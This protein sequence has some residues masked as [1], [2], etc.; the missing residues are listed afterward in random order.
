MQPTDVPVRDYLYGKD[1]RPFAPKQVA[2]ELVAARV[3]P[4]DPLYPSMVK[5]VNAAVRRVIRSEAEGGIPRWQW[6]GTNALYQRVAAMSKDTI[7]SLMFRNEATIEGF[8]RREKMLRNVLAAKEG[9]TP[10]EADAETQAWVRD[11][12]NR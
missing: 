6:T 3:D 1:D 10:A 4:A 8:M 2:A 5:G 9:R 11:L 7:R 12:A